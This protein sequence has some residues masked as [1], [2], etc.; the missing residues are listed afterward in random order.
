MSSV[1]NSQDVGIDLDS[2]PPSRSRGGG[3]HAALSNVRRAHSRSA[4]WSLPGGQAARP[5]EFSRGLVSLNPMTPITNAIREIV[6]S[7]GQLSRTSESN[8]GGGDVSRDPSQTSLLLGT[9]ELEDSPE[10]GVGSSENSHGLSNERDSMRTV[11]DS[12]S[13]V[14][15]HL[16]REHV[17]I[18]MNGTPATPDEPNVGLELSDSMRWLE[19][20]AIFFILVLIKFAWYHR[21]GM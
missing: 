17:A 13:S 5:S 6:P 7:F 14:T 1:S 20:N 3:F 16:P 11:G 18:P 8:S 9:S 21:S 10:Q 4:S 12:G 15:V 19:H 2:F